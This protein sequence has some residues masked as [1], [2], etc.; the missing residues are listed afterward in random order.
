M[1][2]IKSVA[3]Y[4]MLI[5]FELENRSLSILEVMLDILMCPEEYVPV[6]Q[7]HC[8]QKVESKYLQDMFQETCEKN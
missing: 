2:F 1:K 5:D 3:I 6:L 8:F 7:I 4:T